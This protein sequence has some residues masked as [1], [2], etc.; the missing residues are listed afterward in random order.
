[1]FWIRFGDG[2]VEAH[3]VC[4]LIIKTVHVLKFMKNI[5]QS[6]NSIHW[7]SFD[8]FSKHFYVDIRITTWL[9]AKFINMFFATID[10]FQLILKRWT[11][12]IIKVVWEE[13][14]KNG[15]VGSEDGLYPNLSHSSCVWERVGVR[16]WKR[17]A[18][19]FKT[20]RF[21]ECEDWEHECRMRIVCR[22]CGCK[23]LCMWPIECFIFIF[24]N[25]DT[26]N[27]K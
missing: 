21:H 6:K 27:Y 1:M 23:V 15:T 13:P 8:I 16:A 10:V 2:A 25:D 12:P 5:R 17:F 24:I 14:C 4:I 18:N 11:I 22:C 7:M 3:F 9:Q 19:A 20:T 26:N